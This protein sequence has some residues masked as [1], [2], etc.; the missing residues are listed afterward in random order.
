MFARTAVVV[1]ALAVAPTTFA[2]NG[3]VEFA[4]ETGTPE[5]HI[6]MVAGART[7]FPEYRTIYY[8]VERDLESKLGKQ[9]LKSLQEGDLGAATLAYRQR[10]TASAAVARAPTCE[11]GTTPQRGG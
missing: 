4:R 8:R 9:G 10:A 3:V 7:P 6:Q 1:A 5:R 2:A 11:A